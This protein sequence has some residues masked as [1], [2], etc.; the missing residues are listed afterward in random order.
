[1]WLVCYRPLANLVIDDRDTAIAAHTLAQ[2]WT[3][4]AGLAT[5]A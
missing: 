5:A 1:M 3:V 4:I 2:T